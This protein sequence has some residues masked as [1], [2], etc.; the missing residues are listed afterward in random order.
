MAFAVISMKFALPF[1][2]AFITFTATAFGG[3]EKEEFKKLLKKN[4]RIVYE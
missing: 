1:S 3:I 4:R 2:L